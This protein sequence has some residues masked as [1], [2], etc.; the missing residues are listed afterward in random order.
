MGNGSNGT[1]DVASTFGDDSRMFIAWKW[2]A[3]S[4]KWAF[5]A[6]SLAGQ[7]LTDY[8]TG[9]GYAV[10]TSV[11]GGEGF[12]VNA[13]TNFDATVPS[14]TAIKTALFAAMPSGWSLIAAGDNQTPG[15]FN[16]A[17]SA[18]TPAAGVIA[19]NI[20]TLWAWDAPQSKW[21]FYAPSLD[22]SGTL[23][24]YAASKGY[25]EFGTKTLAPAMGFRVN[26][27]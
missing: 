10:L 14:G 13:Q 9:K 20:T 26:K 19:A 25:L 17:F 6:P 2:L 22:Q 5:H 18:T 4:V 1:L 21:Y 23:S 12:W 11:N 27:P 15:G 24:G 16:K 8:A 3:S 7:A